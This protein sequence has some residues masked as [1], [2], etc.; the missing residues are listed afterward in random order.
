[1]FQMM[2]ARVYNDG[3][4]LMDVSNDGIRTSLA[5]LVILVRFVLLIIKYLICRM[6]A[7][8]DFEMRRSR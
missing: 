6:D 7:I 5:S 2:V 4:S 3:A 1:M 8:F